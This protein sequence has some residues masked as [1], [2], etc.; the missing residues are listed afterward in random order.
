MIF[1]QSLHLLN[2]FVFEGFNIHHKDWLTYSDRT[3]RPSKVSYNL[4]WPYSDSLLS[5]SNPWL[6][7][8]Q[9]W[10]YYLFCSGF[11]FFRRLWHVV[12]SV[13]IDFSSNTKGDDPF[14]LIT[15]YYPCADWIGLNDHLRDVPREDIFKFSAS[16]AVTELCGGI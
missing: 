13:S 2:V 12:V 8:S 11:P 10:C 4:E 15:C 1:S 6:L 16:G 14:C 5:H 9:S 7:L 3:D